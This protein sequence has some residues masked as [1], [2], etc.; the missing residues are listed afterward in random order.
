MEALLVGLGTYFIITTAQRFVSFP[1]YVWPILTLCV[2]LGGVILSHKPWWWA[3]SAAGISTLAN[4]L[5]A[6]LLA[7]TDRAI[8]DLPRP[9]NQPT[10]R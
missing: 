4:G 2:A 5:E 1:R 8:L 10:R 6:L 7:M 9:R 3:L